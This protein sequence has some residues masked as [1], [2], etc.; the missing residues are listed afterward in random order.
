MRATLAASEDSWLAVSALRSALQGPLGAS[1]VAGPGEQHPLVL[2]TEAETA[3]DRVQAS[4]N[5]PPQTPWALVSR[6][7]QQLGK[8]LLKSFPEK[9]TITS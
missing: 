4:A 7:Q 5:P 9:K 2:G 3:T 8:A 6:G 1:A